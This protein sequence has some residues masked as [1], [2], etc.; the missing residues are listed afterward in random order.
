MRSAAK[1]CKLRQCS[2]RETP[3]DGPQKEVTVTIVESIKSAIS[4]YGEPEC[5][6]FGC[7]VGAEDPPEISA[8]LTN[9]ENARELAWVDAK[10]PLLT[11][12][13]KPGPVIRVDTSARTLYFTYE[14]E[15]RLDKVEGRPGRR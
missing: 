6:I 2:R 12:G 15:W 9:S 8:A 7:A 4:M 13:S 11:L 10:K 3:A 1:G 14:D 5:V